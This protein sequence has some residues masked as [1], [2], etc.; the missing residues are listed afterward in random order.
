M[1]LFQIPNGK[2]ILENTSFA[3]ALAVVF[4]ICLVTYLTCK[5]ELKQNPAETLR[6]ELPKVKT[7]SINFG[8]KGLL[9]KLSF[10]SKW[11]IRDILRNKLRTAM[12]IFGIAGCM[13]LLV[14]AFGMLDTLNYY[15]NWQ[16]DD[17]YNFEYRL[18]L[19]SDYTR[20]EYKEINKYYGNATSETLGIEIKFQDEKETNN[21]FV[22]DSLD[23]IKFTNH[24]IEF[25]KLKDDGVY[26]TEKLAETK[27]LKEGDTIKWHIYGD[28]IYY[29]SKITGIDRDP[30]NQNV[31][32]TRK[33]LESLGLEYR[34]DTVYTNKNISKAKE[35]GGV[36]GI[37]HI[38]VIKAGTL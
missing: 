33:Y 28:D 4:V 18:S 15:I 31:K 9:K 36:E 6:T 14:C 11:N 24:D 7:K 10:E 29:E 1:R 16:F 21:I 23:Y 3:V 26:I 37:K 5:K 17:L 12:G 2:A 38:D 34:P 35:L 32:M 8:T 25:I 13:M 20:R 22:Y 30:Q 19:K 27:N